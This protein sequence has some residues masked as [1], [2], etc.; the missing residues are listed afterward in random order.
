MGGAS[1]VVVVFWVYRGTY[2]V[3]NTSLRTNLFFVG[4]IPLYSIC[5]KYLSTVNGPPAA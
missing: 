3:H 1:Q 2:F 4:G 5:R